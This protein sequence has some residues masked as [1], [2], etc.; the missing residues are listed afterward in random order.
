MQKSQCFTLQVFIRN[1]PTHTHIYTH[2]HAR[3]HAWDMGRIFA[4]TPDSLLDLFFNRLAERLR[5]GLQ[6]NIFFFENFF[7]SK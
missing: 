6:K 7:Q 1:T 5:W 4:T 3:T 2:T